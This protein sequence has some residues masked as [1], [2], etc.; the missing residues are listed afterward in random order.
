MTSR[1]RALIVSTTLRRSRRRAVACACA[2]GWIVFPGC[3]SSP[4]PS[5]REGVALASLTVTSP[6]F[7]SNGP[8]PVDYTCDGADKS[9]ELTWSAPP[10]ATKS[11]SIVMDDPDAA[12]SAFTHWIAANVRPA[13]A[14]LPEAVDPTELGGVVGINSFN[15]SGYSGPCPPKRELHH[16]F[17]RVFALDAVIPIG[18]D[19]TRETV[20]SAMSGHVLAEGVLVGTFSH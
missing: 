16:Y 19:A 13:T 14:T 20:D 9:P 1:R 10:S 18:A 5:P 15:R 3:K 4:Q 12:S 11:L 6:A 2:I 7:S 8:I 17:F